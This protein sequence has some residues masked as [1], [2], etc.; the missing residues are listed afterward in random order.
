MRGRAGL[1]ILAERVRKFEL[2]T[3]NT[4]TTKKKPATTKKKPARSARNFLEL[5]S[6]QGRGMRRPLGGLRV[7][8]G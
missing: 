3:K 4:K 7:L 8:G 5:L 6:R 2:T 1:S